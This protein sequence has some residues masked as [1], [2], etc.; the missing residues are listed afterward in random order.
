MLAKRGGPCK[1]KVGTQCKAN[2]VAVYADMSGYRIR[3]C[4]A[5]ETISSTSGAG[6]REWD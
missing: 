1:T 4:L 6:L 3:T 2:N 5:S